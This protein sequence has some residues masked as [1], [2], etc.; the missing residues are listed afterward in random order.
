MWE[1]G[2]SVHC[3]DGPTGRYNTPRKKALWC[4]KCIQKLGLLP[5]EKTEPPTL[6]PTVTLEDIVQEIVQE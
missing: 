6:E 2:I 3:I 1:A 5:Q 4:R